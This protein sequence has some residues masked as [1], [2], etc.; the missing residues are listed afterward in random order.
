MKKQYINPQVKVVV[1]KS[2]QQLLSGSDR[3]G[4]GAAGSAD[5]AESR[6]FDMDDDF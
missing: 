1:L 2:R 4:I 6:D 5:N 3:L